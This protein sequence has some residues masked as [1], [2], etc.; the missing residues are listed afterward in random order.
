VYNI[1]V[2][3]LPTAIEINGKEFDIN[4]DY[5]NCLNIILAYED[6]ELTGFEKQLVL[7]SNLYKEFPNNEKDIETAVL[8]GI[9]F[10]NGG[11]EESEGENQEIL[12]RLYSFSK[13][14]NLIFAAFKQTHGIDLTDT[15]YLHWWKFIALF[16]DLGSETTFCNL[17]SL[18]KRVKSGKATKEEREAAKEMGE[19]FEVPEPN[20]LDLEEMEA[21]RKFM[22]MINKHRIG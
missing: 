21:E 12:Y 9:K 6:N 19:F 5:K 14:A 13:D 1:L 22:E 15:E 20:E 10:L 3:D 16:M 17:V 8:K 11:M 4:P 18:R 7:L 2:D